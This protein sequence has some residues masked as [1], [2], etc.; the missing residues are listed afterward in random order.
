VSD[1]V[2]FTGVGCW[3]CKHCKESLVNHGPE[4]KC[5]FSATTFSTKKDLTPFN[6]VVIRRFVDFQAFQRRA[7]VEDEDEKRNVVPVDYGHGRGS[8]W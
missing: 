2:D 8:S 4:G 6:S 5:L 3:K 7:G 1:I